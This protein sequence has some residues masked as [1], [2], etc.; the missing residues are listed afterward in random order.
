[1]IFPKDIGIIV[2]DAEFEISN[3]IPDE[4]LFVGRALRAPVDEKRRVIIPSYLRV[5]VTKNNENGFIYFIAQELGS[6]DVLGRFVH[7][8]VYK[9][10][11]NDDLLNGKDSFEKAFR[12]K[13]DY[14]GRVNLSEVYNSG[15]RYFNPGDI[16]IFHPEGDNL[17]VRLLKRNN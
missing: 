1:M 13:I 4:I 10:E 15:L 3:P 11:A 17:L 14:Q 9:N 8:L 16:I 12:L 5:P 6:P 2:A 7:P